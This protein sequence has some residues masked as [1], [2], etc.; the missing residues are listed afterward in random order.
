MVSYST[1]SVR[2]FFGI[3]FRCWETRV[4]IIFVLLMVQHC[5][6]GQLCVSNISHFVCFGV[7]S[8]IEIHGSG[9]LFLSNLYVGIFIFWRLFE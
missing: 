4:Y 6:M 8:A 1:C 7:T 5:S 3:E 2:V 9:S